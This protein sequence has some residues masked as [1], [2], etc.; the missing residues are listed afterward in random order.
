MLTIPVINTMQQV[1]TAMRNLHNLL[2]KELQQ[3]ILHTKAPGSKKKKG[4]PWNPC[5]WR[6]GIRQMEFQETIS[7]MRQQKWQQEL[8]STRIPQLQP[9]RATARNLSQFRLEWGRS[10]WAQCGKFQ[11]LR[12]SWQTKLHPGKRDHSTWPWCWRTPP[13]CS[14]ACPCGSPGSRVAARWSSSISSH[15][16]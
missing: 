13:P 14:R 11:K 12:R 15:P 10:W 4:Q 16:T 7:F 6:W 9:P 3:A 1:A 5:G 8:F 2:P